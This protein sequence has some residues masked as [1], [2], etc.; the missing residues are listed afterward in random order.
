MDDYLRSGDASL[1]QKLTQAAL[2][3]MQAAVD[4]FVRQ[5]GLVTFGFA[6]HWHRQILYAA[7]VADFALADGFLAPADAARLR[8]QIAFLADVVGRPDYWSP[9]RGFSANPS[10]TT[11]VATYQTYLASLIPDHPRAP[12]LL[13][14]ALAELTR[15][16]EAWSDAAGGWLE[17]PHYSMGAV[18]YLLG[19]AL[20]ARNQGRPQLFEHPRLKQGA[21]VVRPDHHAARCAPGRRAPPAADRQ[22]LPLGADRRVRPL[23]LALAGR[24]GALGAAAVDAQGVR[25]AARALYRRRLSRARPLPL[26][27]RRSEPASDRAGLNGS[28]LFPKT[29][30]VLRAHFG[31]ERE[32][33]LWLIAGPNHEHYDYDSGSVT[34]WGK[35]RRIADDFGY[36]GRSPMSDRSM[37]DSLACHEPMLIDAFRPGERA[38]YVAGAS[39]G[40]RRQILFVKSPDPLGPNYY[41][42]R[43][44]LAPGAAGTWRLFLAGQVSLAGAGAVALGDEDVATDV[45]LFAS[46]PITPRLE[47]ISRTSPT[48]TGELTTTQTALTVP[49]AAGA[50]LVAVIYP[51][52]KTEPAAK[53]SLSRDGRS[54][55]VT[56][57]GHTDTI[58]VSDAMLARA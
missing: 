32:T 51:R 49:L 3:Q 38:D 4:L 35:G 56:G 6:P 22:H 11:M 5:D 44:T 37:V 57:G 20:C 13:D 15:E 28:A 8:A 33:M 43:D 7:H 42:F 19:A 34:I 18:D 48:T 58:T 10:M 24:R 14:V 16:V 52:L 45:R 26:G 39:G 54:V 27:L 47:P 25:L 12:T 30:A 9:V 50:T 29:G 40:W 23:R 46:W 55:R 41:I 53:V 36:T 1:G 21:G 31:T 17:A 2:P